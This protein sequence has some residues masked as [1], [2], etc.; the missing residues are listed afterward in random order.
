MTREQ[1]KLNQQILNY[2]KKMKLKIFGMKE[3]LEDITNGVKHDSVSSTILGEGTAD[4][5]VANTR[6]V[7]VFLAASQLLSF[8]PSPADGPAF[9]HHN[10]LV[11]L[12]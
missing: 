2:T 1:E 9:Q 3:K 5:Q 11:D 10:K 7:P 12:K 8:N 6:A 4:F